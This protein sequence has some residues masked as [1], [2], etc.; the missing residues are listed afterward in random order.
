MFYEIPGF[1]PKTLSEEDLLSKSNE[2]MRKIAWSAR[3]STNMLGALQ[4]MLMMIDNERRERMLME[5]W[6]NVEAYMN[7]TIESDPDLKP[8]VDER[9]VKKSL[10][11]P[12]KPT[13]SPISPTLKPIIQTEKLKDK[14]EDE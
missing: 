7:A 12:F 2:L 10:R 9:K 13:M 14:K 1:D 6:K 11:K 3:F 8:V 5:Q 4:T